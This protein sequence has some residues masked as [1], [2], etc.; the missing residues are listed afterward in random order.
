MTCVRPLLCLVSYGQVK[1]LG[2]ALQAG[3]PFMLS[4]W[5]PTV[6]HLTHCCWWR[7]PCAL[8]C[9]VMSDSGQP[10]GLEPTRL[11]CPW[12]FPG[13]NTGVGCH[14]L[15][16]GIFLIHGMNPYLLHLLY[17]QVDS[18]PTVPPGKPT[19]LWEQL[20]IGLLA[21]HPAPTPLLNVL[22]TVELQWLF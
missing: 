15:L 1:S 4:P 6:N 18:L 3:L 14:L 12:N 7:K 16:Q 19:K 10:H 21:F 20:V 9:T 11:L 8:S 2:A 13:K 22:F 5:T 17:W